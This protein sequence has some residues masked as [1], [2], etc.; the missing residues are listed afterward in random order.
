MRFQLQPI[1]PSPLATLHPF[2][3][4][5]D[6]AFI[7]ELKYFLNSLSQVVR[8]RMQGLWCFLAYSGSHGCGIPSTHPN[9]GRHLWDFPACTSLYHSTPLPF[10]CVGGWYLCCSCVSIF[11]LFGFP[12]SRVF[13]QKEGEGVLSCQSTWQGFTVSVNRSRNHLNHLRKWPDPGMAWL[14]EMAFFPVYNQLHGHSCSRSL[15]TPRKSQ[16]ICFLGPP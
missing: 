4:T 9:T 13:L 8:K 1:S 16:C 5:W 7:E 6:S 11:R 12:Q 14:C 15:R 2:Y 3:E 10:M